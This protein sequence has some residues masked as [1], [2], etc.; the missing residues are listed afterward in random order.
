LN[1]PLTRMFGLSP[2]GISCDADGAFF[3]SVPLLKRSPEGKWEPRDSSDISEDLSA[4]CGLPIDVFPKAAGFAAMARALNAGALAHAQLVAIHLRIPEASPLGKSA[5]PDAR[6]RFIRELHR[7]GLLKANWDPSKHLRWPAG[8]PDRQGGQFAPTGQA[9]GEP[10]IGHNQ[11]PPLEDEVGIEGELEAGVEATGEV[12]AEAAGAMVAAAAALATGI[13]L[14]TTEP[15]NDDEHITLPKTHG[16]HP[17]PKYLGGAVKQSLTNL[18]ADLHIQYHRELNEVAPTK[19]GSS[20]YENLSASQKEKVFRDVLEKIR[21]FDAEYGTHL[22]EDMLKNGF[23][24]S[25]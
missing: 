3:D 6:I 22:Y 14:A 8:A 4:H 24:E 16:H 7:S 18:P 23:P 17:W 1:L 25:E 19:P 21:A 12:A 9:V 5:S 15:L 10:G 11:G 20:H 2:R 13:L